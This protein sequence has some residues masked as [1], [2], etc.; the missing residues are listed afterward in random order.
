MSSYNKNAD[1]WTNYKLNNITIVK[2]IGEKSYKAHNYIYITDIL[3]AR[4]NCGY[5]YEVDAR[6]FL[7][8]KPKT[9][10]RCANQKIQYINLVINDLKCI[11]VFYINTKKMVK[12]VCEK[13][14]TY[15]ELRA[16]TFTSKECSCSNC[17]KKSF[18]TTGNYISVKRY[19]GKIRRSAR[20]RNLAFTITL[21][22]FTN[23]ISNTSKCSLSGVDISLNDGTLSIDRISSDLGY[24]IDNIQC[25]HRD[26]N[27]MKQEYNQEHFI[28]MCSKV[29]I[30]NK[31]I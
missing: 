6:Y 8:H 26:I 20:A 4:C 22:D 5:E 12:V 17:S 18:K 29:A 30:W 11:E 3:L 25:L 7:G 21:E 24:S 1:F 13:C 15:K 23:I 27:F 28:E 10:R 19:Y 2:K 14:N 31:K 9:C 16:G